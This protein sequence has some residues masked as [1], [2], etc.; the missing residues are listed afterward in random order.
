[1]KEL[2]L[3]KILEGRLLALRELQ[4]ILKGVVNCHKKTSYLLIANSE[5]LKQ[6]SMKMHRELV[7]AGLKRQVTRYFP[8]YL[9]KITKE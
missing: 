3:N 9:R 1:M 4:I 5:E 2:G 6:H 8:S 7:I